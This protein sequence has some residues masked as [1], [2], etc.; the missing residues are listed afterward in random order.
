MR[1]YKKKIPVVKKSHLEELKKAGPG[2]SLVFRAG[3]VRIG[4]ETEGASFLY[5]ENLIDY[6]TDLDQAVEEIND[7]IENFQDPI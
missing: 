7:D 3:R 6:S 4:K 5:Y 2:Y 1:I